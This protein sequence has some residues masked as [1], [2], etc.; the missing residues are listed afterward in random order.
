VSPARTANFR[1]EAILPAS[2]AAASVFVALQCTSIVLAIH[3]KWFWGKSAEASSSLTYQDHA[4]L[5]TIPHE[6]RANIIDEVLASNHLPTKKSEHDLSSESFEIRS[7]EL[8]VDAIATMF[9]SN[10][11]DPVATN[12]RLMRAVIRSA[13]L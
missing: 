7:N 13:V 2:R 9:L 1:L 10:S 11:F 8:K 4:F 5:F 12:T 3:L 6:M